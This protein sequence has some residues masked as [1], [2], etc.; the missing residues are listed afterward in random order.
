MDTIKHHKRQKCKEVTETEEIKKRWQEYTELQKKVFMTMVT[1]VQALTQSQTSWSVKSSGPQ[2]TTNKASGGE[3]ISVEL[4]K[5]LN[6]GAFKVLH[7]MY[8]QIWKTHLWPQGWKRSVFI[9]IQKK[10]NAKE[11]SNYYTI[12]LIHFTSQ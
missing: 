5:I 4:I 9:S 11:C 3:E 6:A 2:L 10:G 1:M 12:T 8:Q 7:S